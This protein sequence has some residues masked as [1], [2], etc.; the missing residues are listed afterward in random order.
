MPPKKVLKEVRKS[1]GDDIVPN[2]DVQYNPDIINGL[3]EELAL[4][5]DSKCQ[6]LQKDTDFMATSLRQAF[7]LELIKLP[8]QVKNMPLSRFREEFGDSLEA[9]TRGAMNGM[10]TKKI[11]QS[12]TVQGSAVKSSRNAPKVFQTP[13]HGR[14]GNSTILDTTT[15]LPR[16]PKEGERIL[17]ANGSPLG[18]FSTVVKAPKQN[19]MVAMVPPTPG[20]FV[21][22]QTGEILDLGSVDVDTLPQTIKEDALEKMQAMMSNMQALMSKLGK[23]KC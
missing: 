3:L 7:H 22:L 23:P 12:T 4:H 9:V 5:V 8:T 21:P 19:S 6:Q 18:E 20:V 11:A 17:S 10:N 16:G 2:I 13:S 1:D 15:K 14:H